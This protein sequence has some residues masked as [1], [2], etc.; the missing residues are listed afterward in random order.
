MGKLT[1]KEIQSIVKK[2]EPGRYG[3]GGGLYLM[4][5]KSGAPYWML[6]FTLHKK[7][8]ALTL[9][10][11]AHLSLADVR[12]TAEEFKKKIRNG[13]NPIAE[14]KQEE[15]VLIRTVQD[16]FDDWY[17]ELASR[18]KHPQIPKRIFTKEVSP[19]IGQHGLQKVT[20]LDVRSI[21][22]KVA[23]SNRPSIANDTLM[24]LKQLFNHGIKLGL[25]TYNP[26][27]AFG[28]ND[29]G[30]IEQSRSRALSLDELTHA[31]GVFRDNRDS[32]ARD[33]YLACALLVTLGVRKSELTEST[34]SEFDLDK[35]VWELPDNRSK[36][37]VAITI[38]VPPQAIIW[39]RELHVRA[40][41]SDYVF[42]SRRASKHPHMGSDTLNRAISKLFGRE[43]GRKQ[44]PPNRM[45]ELEHFTVHDLRRTCRSLL[46]AQGVPGHVA[47]RCLN[48][49]LKGVEGV[50]DRYD[51]FEERKA[52][53]C[54]LAESL[55]LVI[56]N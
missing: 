30:G 35:G 33:N 15:Q 18:L 16:L 8:K 17:Q 39:L 4:I 6:R 32:F 1:V 12:T 31:F 9:G 56:K 44:Q 45:G 13:D 37:G 40:C 19:L 53:L 46:A 41:G 52:A 25:I 5:P 2:S 23:A 43:P 22:K 10:K 7:R 34:W 21:I 42:P 27:S 26:A 11:Q 55:I 51:Y 29:A 36:S 47:E 20:P 38:P 24:Y 50:Y 3:D 54:Q 14:R 48:H 49:K 28:V